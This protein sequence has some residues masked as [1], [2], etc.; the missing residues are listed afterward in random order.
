MEKY[1]QERTGIHLLNSFDV[2]GLGAINLDIF[3]KSRLKLNGSSEITDSGEIVS[4]IRG[5]KHFH[6]SP[7]GS[8]CNC[9]VALA[10]MGFSVSFFGRIGDDEEGSYILENLREEGVDTE[11]IRRGGKTGRCYIFIDNNGNRKNYIIPNAND[12]LLREDIKI[13]IL[14]KSRIFH[15]SSFAGQG[16]FNVQRWIVDNLPEGTLLSFDPGEIYAR[17]GIEILEPIFNKTSYL[18]ITKREIE[19]LTGK[20]F[21]K[22][23]EELLN[24]IKDT[25]FIKSGAEGA[26]AFT[27]NRTFFKP[28]PVVKCIDKTGAGDVFA[29][30]IIA[31]ILLKLPIDLTLSMATEAA[32]ISVTGYGR[33]KYPDKYFIKKYRGNSC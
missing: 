30:C 8:A 12:D 33:E 5:E 15:M 9:I 29:A 3:F 16:A 7:G 23:V 4:I 11:N 18:F 13:E 32:S 19:I 14:K 6:I 20:N 2:I 17:K 26:Y 10:R 1:Q 24:I 31:G 25:I 27:H 21:D 28:A 22:A